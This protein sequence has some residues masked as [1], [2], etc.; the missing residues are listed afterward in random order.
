MSACLL[1]AAR[2]RL[3]LLPGGPDG[4]DALSAV[5]SAKGHGHDGV[6]DGRGL[7]AEEPD[8][9]AG[10][11][12]CSVAERGREVAGW[13]APP[14][15]WVEPPDDV[16]LPGWRHPPSQ[17][18]DPSPD[19]RGRGVSQRHGQLAAGCTR[20]L[21]RSIRW[22]ESARDRRRS[23]PDHED[24]RTDPGGGGI[25]NPVDQCPGRTWVTVGRDAQDGGRLGRSVVPADDVGVL[26]PF[27]D[28][29]VGARPS[30][31]SRRGANHC[32]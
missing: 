23:A 24:V 15:G 10:R 1:A 30:A 20:P 22:I 21:A 9:M 26:S 12:D 18:Q 29:E 13:V 2:P 8:A 28:A 7:T 16:G 19:R 14:G 4:H 11:D 31:G 5:G 32:Q 27:D 17:H 25:A 6:G 3:R